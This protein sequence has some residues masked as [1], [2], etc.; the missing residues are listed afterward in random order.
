MI[1]L[2]TNQLMDVPE[3]SFAFDRSILMSYGEESM[4]ERI[5][6]EQAWFLPA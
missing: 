5:D 4:E 6:V 2:E 1:D 3:V